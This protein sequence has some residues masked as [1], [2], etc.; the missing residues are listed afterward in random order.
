M[1]VLVII[2]LSCFFCSKLDSKLIIMT[3]ISYIQ[4]A[5]FNQIS[6]LIIIH[7][8]FL[9][10]TPK[11]PFFHNSISSFIISLPIHY[12]MFSKIKQQKRQFVDEYNNK[13][14]LKITSISENETIYQAFNDECTILKKI[15]Y[16][17]H[18]QHRRG[19]YYKAASEVFPA[20]FIIVCYPLLG[21]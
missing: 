3:S 15:L 11:L 2:T 21:K 10:S 1:I 17:I 8:Y 19:L 16:K 14:K 4:P 12:T 9:F 18:N 5:S 6:H 7:D 13:K 20:I